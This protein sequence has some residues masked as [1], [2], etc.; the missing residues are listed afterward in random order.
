LFAR[1]QAAE[2]PQA[3]RPEPSA[4]LPDATPASHCLTVQPGGWQLPVRAGQTLLQAALAAGVRLPSSCRN[5]SCR[6][7][8]ARLLSG[9]IHYQIDWPGLLAEE[10]AAGWI[11]PCVACADSAVVIDAPGA[12]PLYG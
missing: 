4:T 5:G 7:C 12:S 9:S 11:L 1:A 3:V 8:L 6:S 2:A 10:K